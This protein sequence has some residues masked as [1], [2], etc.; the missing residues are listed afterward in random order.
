M[1]TANAVVLETVLDL[2]ELEAAP[3]EE[4]VLPWRKRLRWWLL[5]LCRPARMVRLVGP[6]ARPLE[7]YEFEKA[8]YERRL[9]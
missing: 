7:R 3:K 8:V 6:N 9:L 1:K 2:P 4:L 5:E